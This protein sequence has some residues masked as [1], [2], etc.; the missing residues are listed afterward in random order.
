M[1]LRPPHLSVWLVFLLALCLALDAPPAEA[2][3][4][5]TDTYLV[6]D[7]KTVRQVLAHDRTAPHVVDETADRIYRV[8]G[9]HLHAT[10][11]GGK[12]VWQ[13]DLGVEK[14]DWVM[15]VHTATRDVVM[16]W[17]S[18]AIT[19]LDKKTG[20]RLYRLTDEHGSLLRVRGKHV[21]LSDRHA[22]PRVRRFDPATGK[23]LWTAR[24]LPKDEPLG[25]RETG[26]GWVR[27]YSNRY[28]YFDPSTG[29]PLPVKLP[30]A[31]TRRVEVTSSAIY[32]LHMDASRLTVHAPSRG[33]LLWALDVPP[34]VDRILPGAAHG[35]LCLAGPTAVHVVDTRERKLAFRFPLAAATG[36]AR[37]IQHADAVVAVESQSV[38]VYEAGS[39]KVLW[40]TKGPGW[41]DVATGP[42]G[43]VLE[44]V[45]TAGQGGQ[46]GSGVVRARA[47]TTG[48]AAWSWPIPG[49]TK[50]QRLFAGVHAELRTG[51]GLLLHVGWHVLE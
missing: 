50:G 20:K 40:R 9:S 47:I 11:F 13:H 42:K 14:T 4:A 48:T 25:L 2:R 36:G 12:A 32:V 26:D 19:G 29:K 15:G 10:D 49:L 5:G 37:V 38:V 28:D 17:T 31:T 22:N 34:T 6:R 16:V 43:H 39:G 8:R 24:P 1:H 27:A 33:T 51:L 7:G 23:I 45:W 46:S 44:V 18:T 35:R 41:H 21:Y 30:R 3:G